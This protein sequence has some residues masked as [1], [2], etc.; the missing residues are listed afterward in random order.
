MK[1]AREKKREEV[2]RY[3]AKKKAEAKERCGLTGNNFRQ[4][5]GKQISKKVQDRSRKKEER[6][7][8]HLRKRTVFFEF[9]TGE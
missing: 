6:K 7:C 1:R 8:V 2:R 3:R 9:R 4:Q 5:A